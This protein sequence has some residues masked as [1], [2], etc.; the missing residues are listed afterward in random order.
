[1]PINPPVVEI[2][3]LYYEQGRT[4]DDIAR[5]FG[6]SR[7]TVSRLLKRARDLGIVRFQIIDPNS[8]CSQVA[9]QLEEKFNLKKAVVV[10]GD[11]DSDD[12]IKRDIGAAG[13]VLLSRMIRDGQTLGIFWGSTIYEVV[14]CLSP[15]PTS[16]VKV[17][18]FVGTVGNLLSHT[19]ADQLARLI[20]QN[21]NGEWHLLPAP[22][23]VE[24][25]ETLQTFLNEPNI[26]RVLEMGK[27]SDMA[28]AGIGLCDENASLARAG[29][30]KPDEI[31]YLKTMGAV[32]EVG[33]RFFTADGEPCRSDVDERTISLTLEDLREI[34]VKIGLAGGVQKIEAIY[35]AI[36]GGY[37]NVLVTD[38]MTA[39]RLMEKPA[40]LRLR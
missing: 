2:A 11:P 27:R 28:L 6:I 40:P 34:P 16:G 5:E 35:G 9:L 23:V 13:A 37:V 18:Q 14:R 8:V 33:C 26:H 24:N 3:R 17:V 25:K 15:K 39:R 32:G 10:E 4:Q 20:A 22:A 19:H 36:A 38:L 21:F 31:R 7:S 30:I 12:L 29:Y 1:M